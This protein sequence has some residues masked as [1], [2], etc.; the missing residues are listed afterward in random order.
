MVCTYV[1]TIFQPLLVS[2]YPVQYGE[3]QQQQKC[4]NFQ[5]TSCAVL[6]LQLSVCVLI[7][8]LGCNLLMWYELNKK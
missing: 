1:S 3:K 8:L 4:M 7:L 2:L 6:K 5:I